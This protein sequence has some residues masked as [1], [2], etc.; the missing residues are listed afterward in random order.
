[1]GGRKQTIQ[2]T[3]QEAEEVDRLFENI[4]QQLNESTSREEAEEIFNK[5]VVELDK[6]GLL[7]GLTKK[8]A[9]QLAISRFRNRIDNR[10][11]EKINTSISNGEQ[12]NLLCLI[13]GATTTTTFY[14]TLST[15]SYAI[16]S[17]IFSLK[18]RFWWFISDFLSGLLYEIVFRLLELN[19]L[20][21]FF[22]L[23]FKLSR[24]VSLVI[25][26]QLG[27][28]ITFGLHKISLLPLLGTYWIPS[29]G[30]LFTLGLNGIIKPTTPFY[31]QFI[32]FSTYPPFEA[33]EYYRP[34]GTIGFRGIKICGI[35]S[36]RSFYL[37][38]AFLMK[39]GETQ[40]H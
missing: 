37:G 38:S 8:Q 14:G 26:F 27:G 2:L 28:V 40:P 10:F 11:V 35:L 30:W 20:N 23:L 39:I 22:L 21:I 16:E 25:P 18:L 6:Y 3:Q 36:G 24:V 5:A 4:R 19:I 12:W 15:A 13:A 9:Q 31:G 1:M 7:G 29:T 32:G 33:Y 34:V 17:L